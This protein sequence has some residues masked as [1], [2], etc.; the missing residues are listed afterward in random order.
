MSL[1]ELREQML[2]FITFYSE[3]RREWARTIVD[4][5]DEEYKHERRYRLFCRVEKFFRYAYNLD[6]VKMLEY[7]NKAME[8]ENEDM[9]H[10]HES[11][12]DIVFKDG[13]ESHQAVFNFRKETISSV[14]AITQNAR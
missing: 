2:K 7:H 3:L 14:K 12:R 13:C 10:L 5:Y 11:Y 8:L 4:D 6:E 1:S 9:E